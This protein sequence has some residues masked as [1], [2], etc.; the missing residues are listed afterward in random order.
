[1]ELYGRSGGRVFTHVNAVRYGTEKRSA[2]EKLLT[3]DRL[4]VTTSLLRTELKALSTV[5]QQQWDL[6][7]VDEGHQLA[8]WPDLITTLRHISSAAS[9]CLVLTATPGRGD[10]NS[11]PE[12][13]KLVAPA[14]YEHVTLRNFANR[15][16][17][18]REITAKLLYSE[19]LIAALLSHG[20]IGDEDAQELAREWHGLFQDD[21]IVVERLAKMENG[22]G[23]AAQGL[24]AH[25]QEHYRIDRRIIRT[26]RRT[27]AEYGSHYATRNLTVLTYDACP[28]EVAVTEQVAELLNRLNVPDTWKAVWFRF[29]CATPQLLRQVLER[30]LSA[31]TSS[32]HALKAEQADPLATDLG[33]AEEESAITAYLEGGPTYAGE[34]T[35]LE[36]TLAQVG[37][38]LEEEP[39]PTRFA[40][41]S[42]WLDRR[43]QAASKTLIFCQSRSTTAG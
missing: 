4:I 8:N 40:V 10:D 38:W 37:R 34:R 2:A 1:M 35:W 9:S 31:L 6:L 3:S 43:I 36:E 29:A 15:L 19:E 22:D 27:L 12:L 14:T 39:I 30:R 24:V 23:E 13:L 5:A 28:A 33:P 32:R 17:P 25:V 21:P 20:K 18:Q 26:R 42:D 11:L 41:L 16:A 7:V